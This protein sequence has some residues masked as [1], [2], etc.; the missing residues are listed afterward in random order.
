[1]P[2]GSSCPGGRKTWVRRWGEGQGY[3]EQV[4]AEPNTEVERRSQQSRG[5]QHAKDG[6]APARTKLCEGAW[7]LPRPPGTGLD[8]AWMD[9]GHGIERCG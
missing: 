7:C 5:R 2:G 1:M 8:G 3:S 4:T 9:Q 6:E